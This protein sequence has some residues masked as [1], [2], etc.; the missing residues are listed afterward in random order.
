MLQLNRITKLFAKVKPLKI[1]IV[2]AEN[3][4]LKVKS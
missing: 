3:H 2:S 1:N 4:S